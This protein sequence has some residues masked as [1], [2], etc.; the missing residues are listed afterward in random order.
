MSYEG[1]RVQCK[2][3]P[4]PGK[5]YLVLSNGASWIPS[6]ETA[7]SLFGPNWGQAI[8]QLSLAQ[9]NA[10]PQAP[11]LTN[12]A[13]LAQGTGEA[14]IYLVSNS[15]KR[16]IASMAVMAAYGFQGGTTHQVNAFVLS[17]VPDGPEI[18]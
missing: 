5:V 2:T 9:F 11:P 13:I 16:H 6:S 12:G 17:Q 18:T 10:I 4:D 15:Q 7:A 1:H 8:T 3:S 14:A